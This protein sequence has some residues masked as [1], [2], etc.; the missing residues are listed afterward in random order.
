MSGVRGRA[1]QDPL[2]SSRNDGRGTARWPRFHTMRGRDETATPTTAG[3]GRRAVLRAGAWSVPAVAVVAAAPA[4]AASTGGGS[5][6]LSAGYGTAGSVPYVQMTLS[7]PGTLPSL[8]TLD[9]TDGAFATVFF[10][11][12]VTPTGWSVSREELDGITYVST[13]PTSGTQ[14]FRVEADVNSNFVSGIVGTLVGAGITS[15][16]SGPPVPLR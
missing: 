6:T 4:H 10:G 15:L 11:R 3:V 16:T 9:I 14:I 1:P 7:V 8:A 5:G 2:R 13:V 12:L